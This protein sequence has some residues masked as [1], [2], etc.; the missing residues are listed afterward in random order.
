MRT[1][2]SG[3]NARWIPSTRPLRPVTFNLLSLLDSLDKFVVEQSGDLIF[4]FHPD[5]AAIMREYAIPLAHD[6]VKTLSAKYQVTL[7]GPILIEVFPKHDDF[8]V[9]TLGLP[10]MIGALGACF[11]RVVTMD[12]PKARDPPRSPGRR[13]CGTSRRTSSRCSSA[14]SGC[15][16]G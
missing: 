9:R 3:A 1:A 15:R 10:G 13:R 5:E 4:K 2:T 7:K 8:A 12:S 11:G 6:A 16:A 14:V